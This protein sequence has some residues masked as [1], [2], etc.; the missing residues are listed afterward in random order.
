MGT[1]GT[2]STPPDLGWGAGFREMGEVEVTGQS[3]GS[4]NV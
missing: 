4:K 3:L 2:Q 1:T